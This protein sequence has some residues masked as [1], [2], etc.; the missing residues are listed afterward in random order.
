MVLVCLN[1]SVCFI[2]YLALLN[3]LVYYV[4]SSWFT[5]S[6][7]STRYR[8]A[9]IS[10]SVALIFSFKEKYQFLFETRGEGDL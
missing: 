9:I 4:S 2:K 3:K 1:L 5:V 8:K 7:L 6:V 10:V